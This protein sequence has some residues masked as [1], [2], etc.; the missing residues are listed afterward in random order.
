MTT[1]IQL[2]DEHVVAAVCT[3]VCVLAGR[4]V[5]NND[6]KAKTSKTVTVDF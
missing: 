5:D 1:L 3:S 6:F 4:R 2:H